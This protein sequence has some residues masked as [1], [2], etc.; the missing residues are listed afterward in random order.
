VSSGTARERRST[1]FGRDL[2]RCL[3]PFF[4]A[5]TQS[6]GSRDL[7]HEGFEHRRASCV[8]SLLESNKLANNRL[9]QIDLAA[10]SLDVYIIFPSDNEIHHQ[11]QHRNNNNHTSSYSASTR[12]ATTMVA[13][14]APK[15]QETCFSTNTSSPAK[16]ALVELQYIQANTKLNL[17]KTLQ[18]IPSSNIQ[19]DSVLGEGTFAMAFKIKLLVALEDANA[20]PE[21]GPTPP[22]YYAL[23]CLKTETKAD[24]SSLERALEDLAVE[25]DI[26]S[27]LRHDN[28]ISL[29]GVSKGGVAQSLLDSEW[30]YFLVLDMLSETLQDRLKVWRQGIES[31]SSSSSSSSSSSFLGRRSVSNSAV[32]Q[33]LQLAGL[34]VARGM[35]YL[36]QQQIIIR[37]LKPENVG[38]ALD[39][40]AKLFDF[41]FARE[42]HMLKRD[43]M[44]GSPRY[45]S[46]ETFLGTGTATF[47]SD[48]FSFGI[49]LFEVC[50]LQKPYDAKKKKKKRFSFT[51]SN[52]RNKVRTNTHHRR[53][54][55]NDNGDNGDAE[56]YNNSNKDNHDP[57]E[58]E[59]D[60]EDDEEED[61]ED[62]ADAEQK[63]CWKPPVDFLS[64]KPLR[65]VISEC[66]AFSA[67]ARPDFPTILKTLES[68][69]SKTHAKQQRTGNSFQDRVK[70][71][72]SFI[73]P[74]LV[75]RAQSFM[76]ASSGDVV[77]TTATATTTD[78][79]TT[80][81]N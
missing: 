63:F 25:A 10:D 44:A 3:V 5:V 13:T 50:T 36:H 16:A 19:V 66:C 46:P 77:S 45:M 72:G 67:N 28:I 55:S 11:H 65:Q 60:D 24:E 59:D 42:A 12:H 49:V 69:L 15:Q 17:I 18:E 6:N 68:E 54:N 73:R 41:G 80:A 4:H 31:K 57:E 7:R 1:L 29:H 56:D 23:K 47:A 53:T 81:T 78:A 26:L 64:S 20:N 74:A 61:E 79:T 35:N 9:L 58:E 14:I 34:G 62:L 71:S 21:E 8:I 48:V 43:E 37:D 32:M 52:H 33:R 51:S 75:R 27:R 70:R 39:G 2:P 40:T 30:G 22:S 38:F 76:A